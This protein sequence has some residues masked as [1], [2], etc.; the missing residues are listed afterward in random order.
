MNLRIC[1]CCGGSLKPGLL[2][3]HFSCANCDYEASTLAPRINELEA[4]AKIDESQRE[5]AL[6]EIRLSNF[7]RL[8]DDIRLLVPESGASM[9]DVGSAH[10][11]FV[12]IAKRYFQVIGIE[13][14]EEIAQSATARG[15]PIRHGFFPDAL[16][17]GEK[18]RVIVFNDVF[19]HIRDVDDVVVACRMHLVDDGLLVL[20]LPNVQGLYYRISKFVARLGVT[21]PFRRMWQEELPSPHLHYFSAASLKSLVARHGFLLERLEELPAASVR[22][23]WHRV[24]YAPSPNVLMDFVLFVGALIVLPLSRLTS[25]DTVVLF[26]RRAS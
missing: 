19:E 7:S 9:V 1:P 3:W 5:A 24:R 11:W 14:D 25:S 26:F 2:A 18:F 6:H 23:L 4:R 16:V 13:P 10:G 22:G 21:G 17:D 20:N 12:E 15:L 8:V